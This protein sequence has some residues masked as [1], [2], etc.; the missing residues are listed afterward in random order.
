MPG[1]K[2]E[3]GFQYGVEGD[4]ALLSTIQALRNELKN[5][6]NQ[7]ERTAAS[8]ETMA[9]AWRGLV[10]LAAALKLAEFARDVFDTA[11]SLGKLNQITGVSTRTLSVYYKAARDVGVTH[12]Q[13]DKGV[14]KLARS[15][16]QLEQGKGSA[17][18]GFRALHLSAKDFVGLNADEK[19]R[20]VTDAFSKL[21]SS[22]KKAA[23]AQALFSK[24][25]AEMIP[26]L[27]ALGGEGFKEVADQAERLG[28]IFDKDMVDGA[29]KAKAA[30]EDVKGLAEGVTA[31]F[32]A[33]FIPALADT[34]DALTRSVGGQTVNG[35]KLLGQE[36]GKVLKDIAYFFILIG[37]DASTTAQQIV[38]IFSFAWEEV[39]IGASKVFTAFGQAV[40][41]DFKGAVDTLRQ[42]AR[43]VSNEYSDAVGRVHAIR[44]AERQ[45]A[46]K[47]R[48]DLF[49]PKGRKLPAAGTLGAGD[50][51]GAALERGLDRSAEAALKQQA[52]DE[53]T[54]YR[55][56]TKQKAEQDKADYDRGLITLE[57]YFNRRKAAIK[58]EFV[59]ELKALG[60]E[61]LGL[62]GLLE[63]TEATSAV[64]PQQEIQKQRDILDLKRQIAHVDAQIGDE[65]VKRDTADAK[66]E[67]E[68]YN[69][70]QDHLQKELDAQKKLA[71]LEGDRA[72]AMR[73]ANQIEDLQ[74]RRELQQLGLGAAEID[75]FLAKYGAA[76]SV[77][78]G[79][80]AAKEGFGDELSSFEN[81]K[82]QIQAT[83]EA[84][85]F[86]ELQSQ[87][88][89]I[90]LYQQEIPILQQKV[91]QLREQANLA[92]A[93]SE[94]QK[95]LLRE[96][97]EE[98]KKIQKLKLELQQMKNVWQ[99]EIKSAI[100]QTSNIV[101]HGFNGWIQGQQRFGQA[102]KQVW[103]SIVLTALNAIE[104]IAAK[105]IEQHLIMAA[106]AKIFKKLGIDDGLQ[107]KS[108]QATGS[109]QIDAAQA[110]ADVFQQAIAKVPFPANLAAAP[111]LAATV[112]GAVS[113]FSGLAAAGAGAGAAGGAGFASGGYIRGPGSATSDSIPIRASDGEYMVS[114]H[115]VES[116]GVG[117]LDL[118]NSGAL[119]G[120]RLPAIRHSAPY[121][122]AGFGRYAGGGLVSPRNSAGGRAGSHSSPTVHMSNSFSA[123]DS[124][125][126]RDHLDDHLDYIADGI[127]A[128]MR[129]FRF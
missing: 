106:F 124:R 91:A 22:D 50:T 41:G 92:A 99:N 1:D 19:L 7:Q 2:P 78:S 107:Q 98:E 79:G 49:H 55:D 127:K 118:I 23:A 5:V 4:A 109:I 28:L 54:L 77:R 115:G 95:Q 73:L 103:N 29:M 13:I 88:Q 90:G 102:A 80:A 68:R 6:Q 48:E 25:G 57:E 87:R 35:F 11:V 43:D 34:A 27:N 21:E 114:A 122:S 63:K 123:I 108:A 60:S 76:R 119:R 111:A 37:L 117:V 128:R 113:A 9:R 12:E 83:A 86:L 67:N 70:K 32:E 8:A 69:A 120:A 100:T 84:N 101:T 3:V 85:P 61:K 24:G 17:A 36:A 59:E 18:A 53:L 46:A 52:Q 97:D 56:L 75:R 110:S 82:A 71:D 125:G 15:F 105:W 30:L 20:K 26:V 104:N 93:E 89:L 129:N 39:S 74:L 31:Q 40:T 121:S 62:Q 112:F 66:N 14:I 51:S 65:L 126:F 38:E 10:E 33:G 58:A 72:A 96:A 116:V 42:G 94:V 64:T 45:A 81:Q 16:V 44:E 47:A